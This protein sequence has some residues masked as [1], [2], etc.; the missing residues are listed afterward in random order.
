MYQV[1][2][3]KQV[4]ASPW[5]DLFKQQVQFP[6]GERAP[7]YTATRG[8]AVNVLALTIGGHIIIIREYKHGLGVH[9]W[10]LPSGHF[11][12]V[13]H[14][15]ETPEEAARRELLE[16]TGYSGGI[17]QPCYMFPS[18]PHWS[19]DFVYLCMLIGVAR[20]Q[21]THHEPSELI[22]N[23][24]LVSIDELNLLVQSGKA[25]DPMSALNFL[26]NKDKLK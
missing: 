19:G 9:T 5:L 7:Y 25:K 17:F 21:E 15:R 26:L 6:N 18:A 10:Q 1:L 12:S 22:S 2:S 14:D 3:A 24:R 4:I 13:A 16:E 8:D 20:Q 11:I 23:V